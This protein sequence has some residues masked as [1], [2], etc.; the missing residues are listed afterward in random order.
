MT[1]IVIAQVIAQA[2]AYVIAHM[3]VHVKQ[4]NYEISVLLVQPTFRK[5]I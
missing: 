4:Y 3:S 5:H 1:D 2:I